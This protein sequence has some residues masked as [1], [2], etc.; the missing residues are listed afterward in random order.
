[1]INDEAGMTIFTGRLQTPTSQSAFSKDLQRG[2][3]VEKYVLERTRKKYPCATL[4][5]AFKGYDIWIPEIHKSIEVK[6]DP[7]SKETG[8]FVIEIEMYGKPSALM[9]STAD[10]WIFYDDEVYFVI[11]RDNII[12]CIFDSKLQY[13]EFTGAGDTKSK[14]AFLV[15]KQTLFKYGQLW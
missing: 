1:M 2:L 8:N 6:Y 4:I 12:K 13:K 7:M 15:N 11:S 10:M 5:N 9:A 3:E 14:K